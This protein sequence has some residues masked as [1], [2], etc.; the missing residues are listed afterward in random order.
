MPTDVITSDIEECETPMDWSCIDEDIREEIKQLNE[1]GVVTSWS[2]SG[3]HDTEFYYSYLVYD[4]NHTASIILAKLLNN[5]Q[6]VSEDDDPCN[7]FIA[8]LRTDYYT[9]EPTIRLGARYSL[10]ENVEEFKKLLIEWIT[11]I[12]LEQQ[13]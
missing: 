1:L 12:K 9:G 11:L 4:F 6:I 5:Y 2:C 3:H 13:A 7:R 8:E 10:P